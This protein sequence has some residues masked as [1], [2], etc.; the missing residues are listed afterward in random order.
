MST[1]LKE[2]QKTLRLNGD[3]SPTIKMWY[4]RIHTYLQ[5]IRMKEGKTNNT[6]KILCFARRQHINNPKGL[7]MEEL[8]DGLQCVRICQ[9]DLRKQAK[10]I[11]KTHLR[12]CLV[13]VLEK[14]QKKRTTA[15]KQKINREESKRMW[16]VIKQTVKDP[17]SPSVLKVQQVINGEPHEYEVQED[18]EN[19][20][21]QE[22][23]IRFLLAHSAPI[24]T[25]LLQERLQNLSDKK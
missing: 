3:F 13:D 20:I 18:I 5:L 2:M 19:A 17:Q 16:Y 11:Q 6:A 15:I 21:Q 12:D 14:K 9:A 22:C 25:T 4:N 24:M 7:T 1:C 10:R 23:E 8:K